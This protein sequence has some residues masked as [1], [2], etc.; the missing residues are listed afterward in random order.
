MASELSKFIEDELK[1]RGLEVEEEEA[2]KAKPSKEKKKKLGAVSL[3][4]IKSPDTAWAKEN[5]ALEENERTPL[6][7][8]TLIPAPS[9]SVGNK[10]KA[11]D[12]KTRKDDKDH[13]TLMGALRVEARV[14]V[15]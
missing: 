13:Q 8:G 11:K 6:I 1:S 3:T 10:D 12:K 9:S 4:R 14:K 5:E 7:P 2:L 15:S